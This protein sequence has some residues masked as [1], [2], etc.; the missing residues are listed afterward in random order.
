MKTLGERRDDYRK[1]QKE[2]GRIRKK[3]QQA[4]IHYIESLPENESADPHADMAIQ[5][6]M[7]GTYMLIHTACDECKTTLSKQRNG[8]GKSRGYGPTMIS[9]ICPGC[10]W[11]GD[12]PEYCIEEWKEHEQS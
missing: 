4:M 8:Y 6:I 9:A 11:Y 12:V 3:K 1:E 5:G 10:G 2:A 7:A